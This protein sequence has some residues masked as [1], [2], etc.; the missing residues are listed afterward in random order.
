MRRWIKKMRVRSSGD[1]HPYPQKNVLDIPP[2]QAQIGPVDRCPT[3]Q[4]TMGEPGSTPA[5]EQ[6]FARSGLSVTAATGGGVLSRGGL[7]GRQRAAQYQF[8]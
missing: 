2:V 6:S 3:H 5:A 4:R 8:G 7:A 1:A